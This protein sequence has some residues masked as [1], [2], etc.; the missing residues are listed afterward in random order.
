MA[1]DL[2]ILYDFHVDLPISSLEL[3]VQI[4]PVY[5]VVDLDYR[6]LRYPGPSLVMLNSIRAPWVIVTVE[7]IMAP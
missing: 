7:T 1:V 4:D 2:R 6:R 5:S 3:H